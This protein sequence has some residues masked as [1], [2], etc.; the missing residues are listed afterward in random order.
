M[1]IFMLELLVGCER[2]I[3]RFEPGEHQ[4]NSALNGVT[5]LFFHRNI[6]WKKRKMEAK[7]A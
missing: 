2:K 7:I 1:I 3:M 6:I 5:F 4:P